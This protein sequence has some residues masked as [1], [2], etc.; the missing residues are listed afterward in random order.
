MNTIQLI[1]VGTVAAIPASEVKVGDERLYNYYG[2][3]VVIKIIEKSAKT[4][5]FIT[6]E[7][8]KYYMFDIRKSTLVAVNRR[9]LDVSMHTPKEAYNT[10]KREMVDA[11]SYTHLTLPTMAVV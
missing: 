2:T 10:R 1:E 9:G 5:T 7:N 6:C 4:L 8:G 11:V 3:A